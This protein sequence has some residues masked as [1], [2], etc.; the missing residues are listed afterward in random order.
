MTKGILEYYLT[1]KRHFLLVKEEF[2]YAAVVEFSP[3][4]PLYWCQNALPTTKK[5]F[6]IEKNWS[7]K[8]AS[9]C[10]W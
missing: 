3:F 5:P 6:S 9:L 4:V 10:G 1:P 2:S 7:T 8:L